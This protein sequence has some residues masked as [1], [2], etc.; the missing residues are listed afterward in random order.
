[1]E[2]R[3][4]N[5]MLIDDNEIDQE[6]YKRIID[7]SGMVANLIQMEAAD[8]ALQHLLS[9]DCPQID[10][11]ILD[12]RMPRMD[13]F[14]FLDALEGEVDTGKVGAVIV[15]LTTSLDQDDQARAESHPLIAAFWNKPLEKGHLIELCAILNSTEKTKEKD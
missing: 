2:F 13:G 7:R 3:I 1:M 6:V 9:P 5:V 12:L 8:V 15:M 11:I 10:A 4:Q 14:E